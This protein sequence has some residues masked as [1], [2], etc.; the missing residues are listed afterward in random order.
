MGKY[1]IHGCFGIYIYYIYILGVLGIVLTPK[2][3]TT[4][5]QPWVENSLDIF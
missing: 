2:F 5:I 1:V 3:I 4:K